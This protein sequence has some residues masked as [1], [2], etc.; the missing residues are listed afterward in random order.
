MVVRRDLRFF[1]RKSCSGKRRGGGG[2]CGRWRIS[3]P[4]NVNRIES[5]A[6]EGG[7]LKSQCKVS[8]NVIRDY[9]REEEKKKKRCP[10]EWYSSKAIVFRGK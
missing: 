1:D 8:R 5:K 10:R 3:V 6:G 9:H 7:K 2:E 4:R